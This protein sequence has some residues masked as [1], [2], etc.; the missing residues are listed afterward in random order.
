MRIR[1]FDTETTGLRPS[2]KVVECGYHDLVKDGS[3]WRID[4]V[5]SA[6][7]NVHKLGIRCHPEAYRVHKIEPEEIDAG[8]DY[9]WLESFLTFQGNTASGPCAPDAYAAHNYQFDAKFFQPP[10][11]PII[12]TMKCAKRLW[13]HAPSHKNG[14]LGIWKGLIQGLDELHRVEADTRVTAG[15]LKLMLEEGHAPEKLVQITGVRVQGSTNSGASPAP[16]DKRIVLSFGEFRG[17]TMDKVPT[18]HLQWIAYNS[19]CRDDI[20]QAA[21]EELSTR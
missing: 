7:F 6:I 12:C 20:K 10:T 16:A 5:A 21:I 15:L 1:V 19:N 18:H 9:E 8:W 4:R 13:S 14:E 2:D 11:K 3:G 17:C